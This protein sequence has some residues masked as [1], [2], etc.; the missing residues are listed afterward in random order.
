M[1]LSVGVLTMRLNNFFNSFLA[2]KTNVTTLATMACRHL[3][4]VKSYLV[5]LL[6]PAVGSTTAAVGAIAAIAAVAAVAAVAERS[7]R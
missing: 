7:S 2:T 3:I 6:N 4:L 5:T 1:K